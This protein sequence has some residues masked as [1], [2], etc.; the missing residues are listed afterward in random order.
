MPPNIQDAS[1]GIALGPPAAG[2]THGS[3]EATREATI[4]DEDKA[5]TT[6]KDHRFWLI[7]LGL[8]VATFISALDLTG[9]II[10]LMIVRQNTDCGHHTTKPLVPPFLP[11]HMR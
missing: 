10:C 4:V 6:P 3:G 9:K 5:N 8:L 7:M 1:A 11:S 2:E